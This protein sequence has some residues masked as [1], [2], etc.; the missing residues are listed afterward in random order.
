MPPSEFERFDCVGLVNTA[1]EPPPS[2]P[3]ITG[4]SCC[5]KP[6]SIFLFKI[7]GS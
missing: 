7:I 3:I 2:S 1:L 6:P 5:T 4:N